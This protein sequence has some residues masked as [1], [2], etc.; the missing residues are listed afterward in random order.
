MANSTVRENDTETDTL[1]GKVGDAVRRHNAGDRT[2]MTD[3]VRTVTPWLFRVCREHRLSTATAEDVVQTTLLALV[4]HVHS[5]RDPRSALSWLTVVARRESLHAIAKERRCDP[6]G[7]MATFDRTLPGDDPHALV[8]ARMQRAMILRSLAALSERRRDLLY[9]IFIAEVRSY[10]T[11]GQVLDMPV[12]SIGP[13]RQRGLDAMR[14][15]LE[16]DGEWAE[17]RSA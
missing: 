7:D 11:I 16:S 17:R 15:R 9:L 14:R 2:A 4:Q 8:E 3:L 10:A 1:H 12:G 13:T 5:V 6:V